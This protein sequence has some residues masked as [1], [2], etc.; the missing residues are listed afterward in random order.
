MPGSQSQRRRQ[1]ISRRSKSLQQTTAAGLRAFKVL[2][3]M[4]D[5]ESLSRAARDNGVTIRTVKRYVGSALVQD[6][7]GGR[8][9][10]TKSD[11]LV[12][13]L[14]IPGPHGP[15]D[16]TAHGSRQATAIASYKVAVNRFLAGDSNA[17]ATW[18]GKTIAGIELVTAGS[19]LKSLAQHEM[20]P[21][22]LYRAL[23]GGGA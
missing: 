9:R 5:G 1:R 6:R 7:P 21:H 19:T 23:S 10:A 3:A 17:L 14:Q 15:I 22:S 18:H 12:R 8:I 11:R 20:L 2:S 4:R 16:I 13:Y